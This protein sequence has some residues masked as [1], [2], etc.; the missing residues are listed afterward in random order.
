M[1]TGQ[2]WGREVA[3]NGPV[4]DRQTHIDQIDSQLGCVMSDLVGQMERVGQVADRLFGQQPTPQIAG[5]DAGP[6]C[7]GKIGVVID[8]L[9]GL[10]QVVTALRIQIDRISDIG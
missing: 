4:S 5:K 10:R 9:E 3:G 8:K 6:T 1:T 2:T 7:P